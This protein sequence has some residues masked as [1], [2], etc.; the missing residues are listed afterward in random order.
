MFYLV[1]LIKTLALSASFFTIFCFF[2]APY[3][4]KNIQN[5]L[6]NPGLITVFTVLCTKNKTPLRKPLKKEFKKKR[7]ARIYFR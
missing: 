6:R 5:I 1:T 2:A 3:K 7:T 4:N